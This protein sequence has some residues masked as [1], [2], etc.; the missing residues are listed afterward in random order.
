MR[1]KLNLIFNKF[2]LLICVFGLAAGSTKTMANAPTAKEA[3]E[4]GTEAYI[5]L[6]PL[7]LMDIT[8]KVMTNVNIGVRP[9]A[10]PENTFVHVRE[11]PPA[12]FR[13]VVR[14]N[15][16][17]LYSIAWLNLEK[18]PLIVS[19]PNT[20]GRYYL[21]PMLDM[22][23]NVFA[24]PGSRTSGTGV[25]H[26]ALV[27]K[28]WKGSLPKGVEKIEAPTTLVWIIGRT[29]T[30]GPADYASV[31]KVQDGYT[32]TP[33]SRWGKKVQAPKAVIDPS[34]DMKTDP[35]A[36]TA[37]LPAEKFFSYA[38]DI[39]K[40]NPAH[41][42]DWS[43][44]T[45]MKRIGLNPG[46]KFEF[47]KLPSDVQ[48]ALKKTPELA[49]NQ[50]KTKIPTFARVVNGWQMNTDTMG[51]Y[52]NYYLK[53]AG[54]ALLGLGANQPEDAIYPMAIT[55]GSGKPV[56]G[57]NNYVIHF[58]KE[59]LPPVSA[60]WSITMYDEEGFQVANPLNR[61][62]I[63][64][65]DHLKFNSDGSLDIYIQHKSPGAD[66]ESNWLPSPASGKLGITMRLY[67]PKPEALDG[68]WNPP[69]IKK[70]R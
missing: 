8:R 34:V 31:H 39:M 5:Y 67:G 50:I 69:G 14:P 62:A 35:L 47:A 59:E 33:L 22:W 25:G 16:D 37:N 13:D 58:E 28:G 27:N 38:M 65:R 56:E 44:L 15:F 45:R 26:F 51:V 42:T 48:E 21:L 63:G 43:L 1:R 12:N 17:T 20:D 23:S 6:Y 30:N 19:A 52:G 9:G 40:K 66:R 24:V 2:L 53:R 57:D 3:Q 7:V 60:F 64:D 46:K 11:F 68:R 70:V 4:I 41:E 18:E 36:Q 29:Q 32:I 54:V 55:D 10:G 49:M 61:F